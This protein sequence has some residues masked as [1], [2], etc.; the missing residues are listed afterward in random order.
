M[1]TRA[2]AIPGGIDTAPSD[3]S[4][5]GAGPD[6]PGMRLDI[7]Y[8]EYPTGVQLA[9]YLERYVAEYDAAGAPVDTGRRR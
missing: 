6:L 3:S 2:S 5:R 7:G 4:R 9:D 1:R 8:F